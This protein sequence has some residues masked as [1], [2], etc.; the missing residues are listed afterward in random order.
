[1]NATIADQQKF[2]DQFF[3]PVPDHVDVEAIRAA[4]TALGTAYDLES[5]QLPLPLWARRE[6][7]HSGATA[8]QML[9]HALSTT[10]Q[11][12]PFCIYLHIPF[13]NSKCGFCDS[14]SFKLGNHQG[15]HVEQYL[16]NLCGELEL[17]S[18]LG[19][20]AQ[21]P[22][23]TVHLGGGTPLF[24]G[25]AGMARLVSCLRQN[26][27]ITPQTEFALET[28]V[29]SLTPD[30]IA[31]LNDLGF[32]RLH[33]GIQSMEDAVRGCI[34]RRTPA[35]QVIETVH[36]T[37]DLD[38]VVSAD[39]LCGLPGENLDTYLD[40]IHRLIG[41]GI[42]GIS[43]Y[44]LLIRK[45]NFRWAE[46]HGLTGQSHFP[47]YLT[48]QAG[49]SLLE[50]HG[51]R[52]NMFNHWADD[53]DRNIYFTFPTRDED[54]LAVGTIADGVFGNYHYRHPRYAGYMKGQSPDR[55]CLEGGLRRSP[56]EDFL[57]PLETAIFSGH[58]TPAM[59][60]ILEYFSENGTP[61]LE[62]WLAHKMIELDSSG[63]AFLTTNGAW[64]AGNLAA[65]LKNWLS[66]LKKHELC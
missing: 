42:N 36:R 49:A 37:L 56:F 7:D 46:N 44:E 20:L 24:I 17:W 43:L 65:E 21:R 63:N 29:Q 35:A 54:C 15:D 8:W 23:S 61:L 40:G 39:L 14:Y 66:V 57:Y 53:K 59:L 18:R 51:Y 62:K 31:H 10:T 32:T 30:N 3:P 4:W 34:G 19:D 2:F 60:S 50:A 47:N 16:A 52:K 48:M 64:F 33:I 12:R 55:P 5:W 1:M 45:Q 6:Y 58:I 28:T 22:V 13:C 26:F 38:W 25:Q 27:A 11:G 9:K 41:A